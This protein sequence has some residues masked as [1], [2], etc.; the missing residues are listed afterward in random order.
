MRSVTIHS[1]HDNNL[2]AL[3][4]FFIQ[5]SKVIIVNQQSI[6]NSRPGWAGKLL[7]TVLL[8]LGIYMLAGGS[9]LISL[10]G[11]W[12][13]AIAGVLSILSGVALF[14]GKAIAILWFSLL[15]FGTLLWTIS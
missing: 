11:N 15:F 12:Y 5:T 13:Y 2:P 3:F 1:H 10:G 7:A 4:S 6:L 9:W 8:L 14:R